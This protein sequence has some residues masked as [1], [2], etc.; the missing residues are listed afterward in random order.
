MERSKRVSDGFSAKLKQATL[1][2]SLKFYEES[3]DILYVLDKMCDFYW[4]T[5]LCSCRDK[6]KL[7]PMKTSNRIQQDKL[8]I[9][10]LRHRL[11]TPCSVFFQSEREPI[12]TALGYEM[13]RSQSTPQPASKYKELE[14]E[15]FWHDIAVVDSKFYLYILCCLNHKALGEPSETAI[16]LDSMELMLSI[17][18]GLRHLET[19]MNLLS[20]VYKEEGMKDKAEGGLRKSLS[21]MKVHNAAGRHLEDLESEC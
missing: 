21:V 11:W 5:V 1:L 16:D 2:H 3:L 10:D 7:L 14:N 18:L 4:P 15:Q 9:E 20:W 19:D 12:P 17:E 13:F 6:I 8:S